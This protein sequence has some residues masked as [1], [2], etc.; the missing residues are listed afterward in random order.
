MESSETHRCV[1]R[2]STPLKYHTVDTFERGLPHPASWVPASCNLDGQLCLFRVAGIECAR[3]FVAP[4]LDDL[5]TRRFAFLEQQT[6][7]SACCDGVHVHQTHI[8]AVVFKDV[9]VLRLSWSTLVVRRRAP[10]N[11]E[12]NC[13]WTSG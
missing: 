3:E 11:L 5:H 1:L 2:Q 9:V 6:L 12:G 13:E 7:A 10:L 8:V 4:V